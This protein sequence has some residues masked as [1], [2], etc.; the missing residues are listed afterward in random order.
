MSNAIV[1][2]LSKAI[3]KRFVAEPTRIFTPI[4]V[5]NY[6]VKLRIVLLGILKK[7]GVGYGNQKENLL[8]R[9]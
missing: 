1:K 8:P 4:E 6:L 3:E 7:L 5:V 2:S 9:R